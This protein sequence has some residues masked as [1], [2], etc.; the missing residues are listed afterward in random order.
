MSSTFP[1]SIA[2]APTSREEL[3]IQYGVVAVLVPNS[4]AAVEG[5]SELVDQ[6]ILTPTMYKGLVGQP[7]LF[8][9]NQEKR[10]MEEILDIGATPFLDVDNQ[11]A[12]SSIVAEPDN[13]GNASDTTC[14]STPIESP[15]WHGFV[16][17]SLRKQPQAAILG[18]WSVGFQPILRDW[19][20]PPG[21]SP[22]IPICS[23]SRGRLA[24]IHRHHVLL[25]FVRGTGILGMKTVRLGQTRAKCDARPITNECESRFCLVYIFLLI[26]QYI[27]CR[28]H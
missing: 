9:F 22:D 1:Q 3:F 4:Q 28:D 2:I 20:L 11:E 25:G 24:G 27:G 14:G 8:L 18:G 19:L 6:I 23:D 26:I 21:R 7:C 17:I 10:S 12:T 13:V 15:L 16:G 5:F